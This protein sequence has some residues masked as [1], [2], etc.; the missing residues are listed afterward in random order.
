MHTRMR[1][2]LVALVPATVVLAGSVALA[3]KAV[4]VERSRPP[5]PASPQEVV[6]HVTPPPTAKAPGT[7]REDD[8]VE[9]GR[10]LFFDP[11]ASSARGMVACADCHR[12]EHGFSDPGT[13]S[14]EDKGTT[15]RHSQALVD[16]SMS[17]SAHWDGEFV[18]TESLTQARLRGAAEYYAPARETPVTTP[19]DAIARRAS[20]LRSPSPA[21]VPYVAELE[22]IPSILVEGDAFPAGA[23]WTTDTFGVGDARSPEDRIRK[24]GRYGEAFAATRAPR[25]RRALA[26]AVAAYCATIRSGESPYDR[27]AAGDEAALSAAARRGWELFRGDAGCASCHLLTTPRAA[28][29]DERYHDTGISWRAPGGDLDAWT[30]PGSV[31]SALPAVERPRDDLLGLFARTKEPKDRRCFKTPTLRD[32]ARHPPF[33]HDGSLATLEDVVRHYADRPTDP[34]LDPL[35]PRFRPTDAQ[36]GDVVAFLHALTSDRRPGLAPVAWSVRA[37]K[38][39]LRFAGVD[40][41][42]L[43]DWPVALV[44]AGDV[45]PGFTEREARPT[46]L[47]TDSSGMVEF[48]PPLTTHTR[49]VLGD[50]LG[51]RGGDL[52]PDTCASASLTVRASGRFHVDVDLPSG[53]IAPDRIVARHAE[54]DWYPGRRPPT[55]VLRR[56]S[57]GS[58]ELGGVR[59]HYEAPCP[60]DVSASATLLVEV[61][62]RVLA[63]PCHVHP[64]RPAFVRLD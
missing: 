33:M 52:V 29:T 58:N 17:A 23:P 35:L 6:V 37:K 63:P 61:G 55:T 28:F 16:A 64:R 11:S 4:S 44:P 25:D 21:H 1:A 18:T 9:L 34:N 40:G 62:D 20:P 41:T 26:Q 19:E 24:D 15:K 39:T 42:P 57:V 5:R 53:T 14:L 50:G 7:P 38:T 8:L 13:T 48:A 27:F 31:A 45:L 56:T 54:S 47:R 36:V 12:A 2:A 10:R 3:A 51:I 46:V 60:T 32:V 59:A 22:A 30:T 49:V 43:A